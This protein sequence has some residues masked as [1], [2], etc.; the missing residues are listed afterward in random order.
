MASLPQVG[1]SKLALSTAS[2]DLQKQ[3]KNRLQS[4]KK[5]AFLWHSNEP[6]FDRVEFPFFDVQPLP[7]LSYYLDRLEDR[8]D[9]AQM[10]WEIEAAYAAWKLEKANAVPDVVVSAGYNAS[11]D[12]SDND[13]SIGISLPIPIFDRNKGNINAACLAVNIAEREYVELSYHLKSEIVSLYGDCQ[14]AYEETKAL[15]ELVNNDA[16]DIYKGIQ[17][18]HKEGKIDYLSL[19][20]AQQAFFDVQDKYIDAL[21]Q[22]HDLKS[23]LDY[24][25]TPED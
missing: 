21:T 13:Y 23:D 16:K 25:L 9:M 2:I 24:M 18:I 3:Q 15:Q 6:D 10:A 5:I 7:P 19:L 12:V 14:N 22:F 1:R 17:E 11:G 20:D 8:P 4:Y